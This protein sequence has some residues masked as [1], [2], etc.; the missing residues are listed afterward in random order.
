M[1][2]KE[3]KW[4]TSREGMEAPVFLRAFTAGPGERAEIELCG[5]GW[6]ELYLNGEK[7]GEELFTPGCSNYES[8][9]NIGTYLYPLRDQMHRRAY[10]LRYSLPVREGRNELRILLGNGFYNQRLRTAEGVLALGAPKLLYRLQV[11]ERELFSDEETLVCR[12]VITENNL[13]YGEKQDLRGGDSLL[14]EGEAPEPAV[15]AE[16]FPGELTLWEYPGDKIIR[17]ITPKLLEAQGT[18]RFYDAGEN[19]TGFLSLSSRGPGRVV[20]EFSEEYSGN[21]LDFESAGGEGQ[22]QH[23]E[24]L[25]GETPRKGIR[26]HFTWHGFRYFSVEGP[27]EEVEVCVVHTDIPVS[28]EF[29]CGNEVLNRLFDAYQRSQLGNYHGCVPSD[30]PHRER[31]GYTG[32][33]QI[34]AETAMTVFDAARLYEKWMQD[35]IDSQNRVNGH[36]QHTAPF[37]GGGGGPCGW[38]GAVAI[39]PYSYYRATGSTALTERYLPNILQWFAYIESRCENGL[40]V[41]EEEGGWCLGDWCIPGDPGVPTSNFPPEFVNTYYLIKCLQITAETLQDLG[42]EE[43]ANTLLESAEKHSEA[44]CRDYY[45]PET[46]DFWGCRYGANAFGLDIGLGDRR[47]LEHLAAHYRDLGCFDTGIFGTEIVPRVLCENGYQEIAFHM[48]SSR[49]PEHSF[50]FMFDSGATTLWERFDGIASHN[51]H[52]FGGCVKTLFH[53]LLGIQPL[54]PG[55]RRVRIA[56]ADLPELGEMSGSLTTPYGKIFVSVRRVEGRMVVESRVPEGIEVVK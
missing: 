45:D 54:A 23:D 1:K 7:V 40:V 18:K 34:T 24:F 28:A 12:S 44:L 38:G 55:Y 14:A 10:F 33:G 15:L 46:G 36:I 26:P 42:R 11:G 20:L 47:T 5:L 27:A 48:L 49:A 8:A 2:L 32:D 21:G 43:L 22:I 41:R 29:H 31:L 35:I 52:M 37:Y 50:G 19:I 3:G 53:G 56:P 4:I 25:C 39:V 16:P 30:C 51:H 9:H 13:F 17:R 6:F